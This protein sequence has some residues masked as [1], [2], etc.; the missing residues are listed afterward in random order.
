MLGRY[1]IF[2]NDK[3]EEIHANWFGDRV[4]V[5]IPVEVRVNAPE[6]V[7]EEGTF[8]VTIDVDHIT[9]FASAQFDLSFNSS[10]VVVTD[11][12]DGRLKGAT[13]PVLMWRLMDE[14]TIRVLLAIP[15]VSVVSGSG[16][17]AKMSFEAMGKEGDESELNLSNG[18]LVVINFTD[19]MGVVEEIPAEWID[20]EIRIVKEEPEPTPTPAP[21]PVHNL[22]TGENFS[23]I[24]AAIDDSDTKDGHIIKA[25]DGIY[26]ENIEVTKSLTIRSENG[27]ANCVVQAEWGN[28]HVFEITANYTSIS[29][30]AV[31]GAFAWGKA[32]IY[33]NAS[34]CSVSDNNCSN[35]YYGI[36]IKDS[37]NNNLS[38]NN[39]SLNNEDGIYFSGSSDNTLSN[40]NCSSNNWRGIQLRN[41]SDNALSNN[42]CLNNLDGIHLRIS[43]NNTLSNNNCSSNNDY[44]IEFYKLSDNNI[45]SNNTCS[46]NLIGISLSGNNNIISNNICFS[47]S[48]EGMSLSGNNSVILNN[49]CYSN[50]GSGMSLSCNN[51]VIA[52]NTCTYNKK[53]IILSN[54][55]NN[56]VSTNNCSSN[57]DYGLK[58][59]KSSNNRIYLNN[60][61][62]TQ[63]VY[64]YESSNIWNSTTKII[65][66]YNG[67]TYENYLGNYWSD[68]KGGDM[69]GDGIGDSPYHI[70]VDR[71]NY[72]LMV[73]FENY[74][75][76]KPIY[77]PGTYPTIQQAVDNATEGV[78]IIV[79]DGTYI[80]NVRVN[81]RLTVRSENG[82][83]STIVIAEDSTE[84]VFEVTADY[85]NINGFTVRG[86]KGRGK[87]GI[88]L[89]AD[90]CIISNNN[91]SDCVVGIFSLFADDNTITGNRAFENEKY[92]IYLKNS[93][94]NELTR[95]KLSNNTADIRL[96]SSNDNLIENNSIL[97][98]DI[99]G[100]TSRSSTCNRVFNNKISD[101]F[102]AI[103]LVDHSDNNV[104]SENDV[105]NNYEGI[106]FIESSNN[107]LYLNNFVDNVYNVRSAAISTNAWNSTS[108][109]NY[110]Y[111]SSTCTN[112]MGN[113][114]SDYN[115]TDADND[116]I[117][118]TPYSIISDKD[119]YPLME[120]F[121]NYS[122]LTDLSVHNI[123]TGENFVAIQNAIDDP[124]T[125]NGHTIT[126]DSG[127]YYE[128]VNVTKSL[129]IKSTSGNPADTIVQAENPEENIFKITAD[130][131][132]MSGLKIT[133]ARFGIKGKDLGL[134]CGIELKNSNYT[135][136]TNCDV[137]N[138]SAGI[139][140][141]NSS[142]NRLI[143]NNASRGFLGIILANS[144]NNTLINNTAYNFFIGFPVVHSSDNRLINNK[145]SISLAGIGL[146]NSSNNKLTRNNITNNCLGILFA[147]SSYN[148]IYLNNFRDN[149]DNVNLSE[150][151]NAWNST[152][153][154]TYTC[155]GSTFTNYM[156]NCWDDYNGT[157]ADKDGIG[158]VP[159]NINS[160][161][162]NY[163][164]MEPWEN[165]FASIE[166]IFDTGTPENPYPSI[167]GTHNGTITPSRGITVSMLYT[168]PCECTGGHTEYVRIWNESGIIAE[169]YWKGYKGDW[170]NIIFPEAFILEA[171]KTY[172]YTIKTGSYPQIHHTDELEVDGGIIK[173]T[174]FTDTN[175]KIY[176]NW[177]PAIRLDPET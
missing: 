14:N 102:Y 119:N 112:Y 177:I 159:Y 114:W 51:N 117:G 81:K 121:E 57:T 170:H 166:N 129:T 75:V 70:Y 99:C 173:C 169:A 39:C 48:L 103:Y 43:R 144:R 35:N 12:M 29:G 84:N 107:L 161:K 172:N 124:D 1:R 38:N 34:Y 9:N 115:G 72:P 63:N 95:N 98:A 24:Q 167:S 69:N 135:T 145:A 111:N 136:L 142:N 139:G 154:I 90:H 155:N 61:I 86:A 83:D 158:D 65:Y 96:E 109:M 163:P 49:T 36:S 88:Y 130:Y 60:F 168:Y 120:Q 91:A 105:S 59:Y 5:V 101:C 58:L 125:L 47:N 165:Y 77:V 138:N 37:S 127:T 176:S 26:Y 40:N 128:N 46:N 148:F 21:T 56:I 153:K 30:F 15:G 156:G 2:Y 143:N 150:S 85:T 10:V 54:S 41:S 80:E 97:S 147:N 7:E 106:H 62:N 33:L 93:Y 6:Y 27:S 13:I 66:T 94:K 141:S 55:R 116:G 131:V 87:A 31:K 122:A 50:N 133:G 137:S 45:M 118:D 64:Y 171:D 22:D 32:G 4:T 68:Y 149:D 82:S 18:K 19:S 140:I 152:E 11:V 108:K 164:L 113:Y 73:R 78:V 20:A 160:D 123:D 146:M 42:I 162:D 74:Y 157:D 134:K 104:V 25:E 100:I 174:E 175:G 151:T 76:S 16:Y 8:D 44:G 110:T 92:G 3:G 79:R 132:N 89:N 71:D 17:L 126:I 52:N 67:S 28:D 53:G 23:S